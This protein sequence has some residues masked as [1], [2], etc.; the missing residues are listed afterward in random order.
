LLQFKAT[1]EGEEIWRLYMEQNNFITALQKTTN[2][3]FLNEIRK[4]YA[5]DCLMKNEDMTAAIQ[6]A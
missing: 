4:K 1:S 5:E 6:L 2:P 3:Q